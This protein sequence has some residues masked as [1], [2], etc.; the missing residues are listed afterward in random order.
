MME[1]RANRRQVR[2]E[3]GHCDPAELVYYPTYF[4][5]FDQS[6]HHLFESV[7]I[8]W[9]EL[10]ARFGIQA[11]LVDAQVR[12]ISPAAWGDHLEI[13]SC[14]ERWGNRSFVVSHRIVNA[15]TGISVAEGK[16]TRVCV[17]LRPGAPKG[18]TATPIP[19]DIKKAFER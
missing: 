11:P 5:W 4:A 12:F 9:R 1:G 16:E 7:G 8:S 10:A 2:V 19:S 18:I 14:V 13:E 3:F 15:A 17:Q 6:T